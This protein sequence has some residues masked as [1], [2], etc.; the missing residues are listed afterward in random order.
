LQ[1]WK[2]KPWR[3]HY[4][5]TPKVARNELFRD[6][7]LDL[8]ALYTRNPV[9]TERIVSVDEMTSLQPRSRTSDTK[10]ARPGNQPVLLEHE[11]AR[12]GAVN[13][14]AAFDIQTG[15]VF[16]ITRRR[17]RQVE[18]IELLELLDEDTPD[19]VTS[20]H[21]VADNV[22]IHKGKI[23]QAWLA[24]HPRFQMHYTPVH[25]SWMNQI[26]QWFSILR[27][28]RLRA[29]NFL[30]LDDL[31]QKIEKFIIEWNEIAH[32]FKW[33]ASSFNKVLAKV[34]EYLG[35]TQPAQAA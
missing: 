34:D 9:S 19:T 15:M 10:P 16:G 35:H 8:S 33:T 23:T 26:E 17:K 3:V 1:S 7:V 11:Y 29:P 25:C 32:P 30:D 31:T 20:I 14:F 5:L 22:S 18:F 28:K 24:K 4:W 21:V 13:L 2:L 6:L 27:R 12:K